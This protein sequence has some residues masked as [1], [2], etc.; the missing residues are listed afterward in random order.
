MRPIAAYL[1]PLHHMLKKVTI[2]DIAEKAEVSVGLVSMVLNNKKG[3]NRETADRIMKVVKKMNYTPNKAASTLRIGY[4]KTIGVITPDLANHYFSDISRH[5]ENIAF[6]N[7]FT[8]LFGSSDDRR[9]K[10]GKLIETFYSDGVKGI[11]LSPCDDCIP[12]IKKALNLGISVVLMNRV[13]E[14]IENVGF[15]TLDNDK[16]IRMGIGHLLGNGFRHIEMLSN[17]IN[18]STLK[19][20]EHCY[21]AIMHELGMSDTARISLVDEKNTADL[22]S[23]ILEAYKRGTDAF[24]IPRGYLALHVNN[25]IKRL[26]LRIPDDIAIIG[27]DGGETYTLMTP[28]ISQLVQ[29]TRETAELSYNMLGSMM[30]GGAGDHILIE[31]KL[32]PGD[33]TACKKSLCQNSPSPVH[34]EAEWNEVPTTGHERITK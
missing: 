12:E 1:T 26:G 6:E 19:L 29:D 2:K 32:I 8:V 17:N 11:L 3:V 15:V 30:H 31:P 13:P 28:S 10:V 18:L 9:D 22:D 23:T 4:K 7:G 34:A 33:S 21:M 14:G 20:R 27:F 16:A 24:I 5:I 25:S